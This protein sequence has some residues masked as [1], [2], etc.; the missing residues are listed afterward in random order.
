MNANA[1]W[2]WMLVVLAAP[3]L[4]F[5]AMPV[6]ACA[7]PAA[8]DSKPD[9]ILLKVW[10]GQ[11]KAADGSVSEVPLPADAAKEF[12]KELAAI[13]VQ[14]DVDGALPAAL[15]PLGELAL[16]A[17][18]RGYAQRQDVLVEI[19][20]VAVDALERTG[21][22]RAALLAAT[23]V[24]PSIFRP[25]L[26]MLNADESDLA[27]DAKAAA[28]PRLVALRQRLGAIAA[29]QAADP[30][31][32]IVRRALER[33]DSV[34]IVD[35][36]ERAVPAL[37]R[38]ILAELESL[39]DSARD[40][41]RNLMDVNP[42]RAAELMRVNFDRGGPI[43]KTRMLRAVKRS[44]IYNSWRPWLREPSSS[45]SSA[46]TDSQWPALLE[47][48]LDEP[49][50]QTESLAL[51]ALGFEYDALTP[52]LQ[53]LLAKL[54][55]GKD[56]ALALSLCN[57]SLKGGG[58]ESVRPVYEAALASPFPQVRAFAA[59]RLPE[60]PASPALLAA[61]N[62]EDPALR[63]GAARMLQARM[64]PVRR[65]G[66]GDD[67]IYSR[68]TI[69]ER[70]R[71]ILTRL[72]ADPHADVRNQ[73]AAAIVGLEVP[74]ADAIYEKIAT[75]PDARVRAQL[76][77]ARNISLAL[78]AKVATAAASDSDSAVVKSF[79]RFLWE[80]IRPKDGNTPAEDIDPEYYPA[81]RA[82][83]LN[84]AMRF[85]N[86]YA[87]SQSVYPL[88]VGRPTGLHTMILMVAEKP[89]KDCMQA[90]V[91]QLE[92]LISQATGSASGANPPRRVR[93]SDAGVLATPGELAGLYT[94]TMRLDANYAER[95]AR[96]LVQLS[97]D[98]SA[99]FLPI[100][101][102]ERASMPLRLG[103]LRV[104]SASAGERAGRILLSLLSPRGEELLAERNSPSDI[105][106]IAAALSG[107]S[108]K[109]MLDAVLADKR[110][111]PRLASSFVNGYASANALDATSADMIL[112]RWFENAD[113]AE[114]ALIAALRQVATRPR[115]AQGDW[116]LR[117][118]RDKRTT[119]TAFTLIGDLRDPSYLELLRTGLTPAFTLENR[120]LD[121]AETRT[122]VLNALTRYFDDAAADI[123]L[124]T[125]GST[126]SP[127]LREQCF[128]ALETIRQYQ[129]EKGRWVGDR[130]SREA[131][132]TAI[133]DLLTLLDDS[134]PAVRAQAVRGL[135]TLQ[136]IEQMPR[137]VRMLKDSDEGVRKAAGEA[138]G[139]LNA[140]PQK[141]D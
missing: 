35:L 99:S 53:R 122:R 48:L 97:D 79:D 8:Q 7:R 22:K 41:L 96:A 76:L 45:S 34:A 54:I 75:D 36:G 71:Q 15:T 104:A 82:R 29:P 3:M 88:L 120:Q 89:D 130:A 116:L 77:S 55:S 68:P 14:I 23:H 21:N 11:K 67:S 49:S 137:I 4:D 117:A 30:I 12:R 9:E 56:S 33:G 32:D 92:S 58:R 73:A 119:E 66:Q 6:A 84:E 63:A 112:S 39:P 46:L 25:E 124:S 78:R 69:G 109:P 87:L 81:I 138:L 140:P 42:G 131:T 111:H 103:A 47:R 17:S 132:A 19:A 43:W 134:N 113:V 80:L 135:A 16:R 139:V 129:E 1:R 20:V 98:L 105:Y 83:R 85:D 37:E 94:A 51:V 102:D 108:A 27:L 13:Q 101:E 123:I 61:I 121:P 125:A 70:E 90:T 91:R 28:D 5:A 95:L 115:E 52:G 133:R 59:T 106:L 65:P 86:N 141:Q 136:A 62:H 127:N 2:I 31:D 60:W 40:P 26:V 114:G 44:N 24:L 38:L 74:L 64:V 126:A 107:S 110:L 93:A 118:A 57:S 128:K 18:R 100:A 72:I 10:S 50:T